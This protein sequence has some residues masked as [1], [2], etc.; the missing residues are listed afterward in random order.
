MSN[1]VCLFG[2]RAEV[3]CDVVGHT[4][5]ACVNREVYQVKQLFTVNPGDLVTTVSEKPVHLRVA[6]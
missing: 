1:K 5:F 3:C 4:F 2:K 6:P